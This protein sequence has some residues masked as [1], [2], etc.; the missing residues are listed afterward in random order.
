MLKSGNGFGAV[1]L[2]KEIKIGEEKKGEKK[3]KMRQKDKK[4]K[5]KRKE[6]RK[7]RK[8]SI[9]PPLLRFLDK[10]PSPVGFSVRFSGI[11]SDRSQAAILER[12]KTSPRY[13]CLRSSGILVSLKML[14]SLCFDPFSF[15]LSF[16]IL[17]CIPD[18]L[19]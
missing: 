12:P 13:T 6:W 3:M 10:S 9:I 8:A 14:P 17:P 18:W 7:G 5:K 2:K 19:D 16:R 15:S 4:K 11:L 1:H